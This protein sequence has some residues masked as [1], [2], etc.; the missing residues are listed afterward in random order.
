MIYLLKHGDFSSSQTVR[1]PGYRPLYPYKTPLLLVK[2]PVVVVV[3]V[4][5]AAVVV[6]VVVVVVVKFPEGATLPKKT[7]RGHPDQLLFICLLIRVH[8]V[9]LFAPCQAENHK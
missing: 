2:P 4:A 3:A 6:V 9:I 8:H 1:L 5:A 7:R